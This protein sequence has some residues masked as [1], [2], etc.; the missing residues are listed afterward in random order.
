VSTRN[1]LLSTP[2]FINKVPVI[3]RLSQA[4]VNIPQNF[5]RGRLSQCPYKSQPSNFKTNRRQES[6]ND[7]LYA[8][9]HTWKLIASPG[10]QN[11]NLRRNS[12][13][14]I[15]KNRHAKHK[16]VVSL[17]CE[18]IEGAPETRSSGTAAP[19][20]P[21]SQDWVAAG[22]TSFAPGLDQIV[23]TAAA[24]IMD[25]TAQQIPVM[26]GQLRNECC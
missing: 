1:R 13:T 15:G 22:P 17:K 25:N 3:L 12:K 14:S 4:H 10:V 5:K 21:P 11:A 6:P 24:K 20:Y 26:N 7:A 2:A 18:V 16:R 9:R 19:N 23:N 8:S